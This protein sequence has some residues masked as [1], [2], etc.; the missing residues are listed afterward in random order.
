MCAVS[1]ISFTAL[2]KLP[3]DDQTHIIQDFAAKWRLCK[4]S[5][6]TVTVNRPNF[7]Y[8][9]VNSDKSQHAAVVNNHT[10]AAKR[11]LFCSL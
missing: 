11:N 5:Y 6:E 8:F 9:C 2:F 1:A 4:P 3:A 10:R 7:L